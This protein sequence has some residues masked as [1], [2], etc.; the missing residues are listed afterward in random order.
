MPQNGDPAR[1]MDL[2]RKGTSWYGASVVWTTP[3]A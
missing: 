1:S 2:L 3:R